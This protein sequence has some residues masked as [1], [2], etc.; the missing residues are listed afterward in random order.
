MQLYNP[1]GFENLIFDTVQG[2]L[3][4]FTKLALNYLVGRW[5]FFFQE[6]VTL[7]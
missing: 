2:I 6:F 7:L 5:I 4:F 1:I 3:S